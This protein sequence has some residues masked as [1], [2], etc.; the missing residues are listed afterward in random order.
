[1]NEFHRYLWNQPQRKRE[2]FFT[3]HLTLDHYIKLQDELDARFP[4]RRSV[5]YNA[6][7][8]VTAI[9]LGILR[10][11][12]SLDAPP[13]DLRACPLMTTNST[14]VST[15]DVEGQEDETGED[16][17]IGDDLNPEFTDIRRY[18]PASTR[19]VD[20]STIPFS[21]LPGRCSFPLLIRKEYDIME[22][23]LDKG[24]RGAT[25]SVVLTGQP[26]IGTRV[27]FLMHFF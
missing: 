1:L 16:D 4:D 27:G 9:K 23:I 22:D 20:L 5:P 7:S 18:L 3:A 26:G 8:D 2:I 15:T 6:Q 19:Y 24:L 25:G 14:P 17:E 13:T 21:S 11:A 10:S 12:L